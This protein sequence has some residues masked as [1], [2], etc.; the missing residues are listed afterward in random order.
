[1]DL[2]DGRIVYSKHEHKLFLPAS[3]GKLFSTALA[4][5]RLGPQYFHTTAV[6][7]NAAVDA[8]GTLEGDLV[9][10][11]GGDPNLS[12]RLIPYNPKKEFDSDR[13]A[14]LRELAQQV[15]AAGVKKIVGS[16][17]GDDRRY[18]WQRHS[19]GWSIDDGMWGYGAP[20]SALSFNDNSVTMQV[21]PGRAVRE[22]ARVT[23]QPDI[24]YFALDNRLRTAASRMVPRGLNL[25][26]APG[27]PRAGALGGDFD[28]FARS[29]TNCRGGRPGAVCSPRLRSRAPWDGRRNQRGG[30]CAPCFGTRVS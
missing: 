9:L 7:S 11:G 13:L 29:K 8:D 26:R 10:L 14:P 23:F 22:W 20:I 24:G 30:D 6:V 5:S 1:M 17:V 4:L 21:L 2:E 15:S 25:D 19:P 16:V 27:S 3:N 28:S 12:S 18:V